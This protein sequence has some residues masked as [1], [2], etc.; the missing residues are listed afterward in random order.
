VAESPGIDVDQPEL[1]AA[2]LREA[3]QVAQEVDP[4]DDAADADR[5]ELRR[6]AG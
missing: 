2:E 3:E 4:E 5:D 1:R 6:P